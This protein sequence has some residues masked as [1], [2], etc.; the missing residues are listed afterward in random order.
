MVVRSDAGPPLAPE[1]ELDAGLDLAV[2]H[3]PRDPVR[4]QRAAHVRDVAVALLVAPSGPHPAIVRTGALLDELPE[5]AVLRRVS[6]LEIQAPTA[7][8]AACL[9]ESA[10][11]GSTISGSSRPACRRPST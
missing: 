3:L 9:H 6:V 11:E 7:T 8:W 1:H 2:R 10:S 4:V 5:P